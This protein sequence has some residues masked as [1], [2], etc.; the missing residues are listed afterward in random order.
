MDQLRILVAN[1]PRAYRDVIAGAFQALRPQATVS[2]AAP[3]DL[4]REVLR[5]APQLVICSQLTDVVRTWP[6]AWVLLYP[7][8]ESRAVVSLAGEQTTVGEIE[9]GFLLGLIDRT[10]QRLRA[11]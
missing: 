1:E 3:E 4:D 6:P 5:Q 2:T 10:E 8:G 9:F 7:N 11:G